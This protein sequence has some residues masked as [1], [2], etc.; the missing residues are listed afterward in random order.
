VESPNQ[1][2]TDL[3][4]TA[5]NKAGIVNE[6]ESEGLKSRILAGKIKAEDWSLAVEKTLETAKKGDKNGK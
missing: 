6:K 3:I 1:K 5:L 2:L 4:C